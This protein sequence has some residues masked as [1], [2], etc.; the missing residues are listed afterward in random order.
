[1]SELEEDVLQ[2]GQTV[3]AVVTALWEGDSRAARQALREHPDPEV[4]LFSAV[5][6]I[7]GLVSGLADH[8]G[9][10]R[11]EVLRYVVALSER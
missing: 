11:E 4:V 2:G 1:M 9:L 3:V 5:G 10:S 7:S 8:F 6:I